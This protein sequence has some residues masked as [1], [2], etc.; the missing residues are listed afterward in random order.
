MPRPS[1]VSLDRDCIP[2]VD[3]YRAKLQKKAEKVLSTTIPAELAKLDEVL[4]N[5]M[6][7]PDFNVRIHIFFI[8][9]ENFFRKRF[10][11][12]QKKLCHLMSL[13][14]TRSLKLTR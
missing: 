2:V 3:S 13:C 11:I 6:M 1:L 14:S 12:L 8:K 5:V 9:F 7:E 4:K 10:V